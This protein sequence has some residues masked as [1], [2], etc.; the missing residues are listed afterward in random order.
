MRTLLTLEIAG[1]INLYKDAFN[2]EVYYQQ[3][4]NYIAKH[5]IN[6]NNPL[7]QEVARFAKDKNFEF[8]P[9][10]SISLKDKVNSKIKSVLKTNSN[11]NNTK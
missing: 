11:K 1:T 5:I 8:P 9:V 7:N 2:L 6:T 3:R 10:K 4:D